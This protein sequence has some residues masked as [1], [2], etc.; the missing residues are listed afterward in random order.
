[1][2]LFEDKLNQN[3]KFRSQVFYTD[4]ETEANPYIPKFPPLNSYYTD[5][6]IYGHPGIINVTAATSDNY[7]SVSKTIDAILQSPTFIQKYLAMCSV[8]N[9]EN[10]SSLWNSG[11]K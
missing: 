4:A 3:L 7:H 11:Y 10:I 2:I 1:M 5:L 9:R 8:L 6:T